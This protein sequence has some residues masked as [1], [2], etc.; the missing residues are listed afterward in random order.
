MKDRAKKFMMV[1]LLTVSLLSAKTSYA[2]GEQGNPILLLATDENFGS[3]IGEILRTEGFNEFMMEPLN[4]KMT[5]RYLKKY[6]V[7]IL[8]ESSLTANQLRTLSR[9]VKGGGNLIAFKPDKK[10]SEVFGIE[11]ANGDI[12]EAYVAIDTTNGVG[13]G[14]TA[15]T[16]QFHGKADKYNLKG[17]KTIASIYQDALTTS[18]YP[19]V[20][21]NDYGTGHA[22]AFLYNLPKSIVYTRQGNYR[23]AGQEKDGI[24]GLRPMDLFTDGWVDTSKN[25]L[26]QSD[27]QMRLFSH[28]IEKMNSYTKPLPRFWY[29]PDALNCLVTLNNDGEQS[30]EAEFTPQFEDVHS[31]GANMTLY[32]KEV[33]FISKSWAQDWISKGFEISGHPNDTGQATDP[34]W[35]TMSGVYSELGNKLNDKLGIEAMHTVTNH[36]FVWCGKNADGTSDF[37]AQAKI[38]ANYGIGLDCNYAHYDNNSNQGHFLGSFGVD[39]GNYTGSGLVMKFSDIQGDIINVYQQL[40]NVYDQQYMEHND[41]D[42]YFNSFK[43]LMDRSLENEVYSFISVKA[44]NDE[45]FFSKVPLMKMLDYANSKGI[46]VWTELKLLDFLKTKD[47]ATFT[48]IVW[49]KS[50][51]S[52]KISSSLTHSNKLAC[53]VPF[54]YEDKKIIDITS[55]GT[56]QPYSVKKIKGFDYAILTVRPGFDYDI[57][58]SYYP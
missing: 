42:G 12:A 41:H 3:F 54:V 26:N 19:A 45:Y 8:A 2:T 46:P 11:D 20:V 23:F 5:I 34:D 38:E 7:V 48:S 49:A 16:M 4:D 33:D 22:I 27:E 13:R 39:Q 21:A 18:G 25:T 53:M 44:H 47:E 24:P 56:K 57:V 36:W 40:N 58:I 14:I 9:Y 32:V 17:G 29:F 1:V 30:T 43:G 28:C 52:F 15:E 55:N 35:N 51:L 10:L 31:K 6:D 37:T 50:K